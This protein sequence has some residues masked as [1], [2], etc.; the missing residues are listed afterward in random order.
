MAFH[1]KNR[2]QDAALC[3]R[4]EGIEPVVSDHF[5]GEGF[6]SVARVI[7]SGSGK[8]GSSAS[9]VASALNDA[10]PG[11]GGVGSI[12]VLLAIDDPQIERVV[13]VVACKEL[14]GNTLHLGERH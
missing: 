5:M 6:P 14:I 11:S 4:R 1:F 12:S 13:A 8:Y 10:V 7:Q 3:V 9:G 2:I